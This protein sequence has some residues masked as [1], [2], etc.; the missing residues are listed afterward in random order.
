MLTIFGERSTLDVWQGSEYKPRWYI[1]TSL[2]KLMC[3]IVKSSVFIVRNQSKNKTFPYTL[4]EKLINNNSLNK[5]QKVSWWILWVGDARNIHKSFF[6][7]N[8]YWNFKL[9]IVAL[10][11]VIRC[12]PYKWT[13]NHPYWITRKILAT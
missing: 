7:K 12:S 6:I 3:V 13:K 4:F 9:S 5:I 1:E 11:S 2:I 10:P 8:H